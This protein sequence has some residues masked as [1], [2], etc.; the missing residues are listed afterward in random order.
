MSTRQGAQAPL[1]DWCWFC[2]ALA[3]M[4]AAQIVRLHQHDAAAWLACDLAGRIS[5]L[6]VLAAVRRARDVVFAPRPTI[7]AA[8]KIALW[9]IGLV[10]FDRM[11]GRRLYILGYYDFS[12]TILGHYPITVGRL[13]LLDIFVDLPLVVVMEELVFR[14][15]ARHLL[16]PRLGDGWRMTIVSALAFGAFHWW[17]GLGNIAAATLDGGLLMIFYRRTGSLWPVALAHYAIDFVDF[18]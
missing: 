16:A 2:A 13:H 15:Y 10:L 3:P 11:I 6:I 5:T 8:W 12:G 14:R 7:M 9:V 4:I 17:S 1:A 18:F